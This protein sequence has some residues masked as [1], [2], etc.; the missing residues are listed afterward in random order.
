[1]SADSNC[2]AININDNADNSLSLIYSGTAVDFSPFRKYLT[3]ETAYEVIKSDDIE[4]QMEILDSLFDFL[5]AITAS[6]DEIDINDDFFFILYVRMFVKLCI[7]HNFL[8]DSY[9]SLLI[10]FFNFIPGLTMT[11]TFD[12]RCDASGYNLWRKI[13]IECKKFINHEQ[14]D[15]QFLFD[16]FGNF[17][18]DYIEE[19]IFEA[20]EEDNE[21]NIDE[22]EFFEEIAIL[23]M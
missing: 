12:F 1:M 2:C 16:T 14:I 9:Y 20:I 15:N 17:Y 4:F 7:Y 5:D 11:E 13:A 22:M 19:A 8:E 10:S 23:D 18:I 6:I 3:A 21:E